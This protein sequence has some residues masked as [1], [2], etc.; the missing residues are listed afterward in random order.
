VA[1]KTT[2]V[3]SASRHD[4][5]YCLEWAILDVERLADLEREVTWLS[6]I[7]DSRGFPLER[8]RRN[9]ELAADVV[10]ERLGRDGETVAARLRAV[11]AGVANSGPHG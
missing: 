1:T 11:A 5:S 7:L 10:A 8:L 9:L 3:W 2:E 6:D 4:T